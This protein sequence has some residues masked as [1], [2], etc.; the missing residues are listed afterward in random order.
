MKK[1]LLFALLLL[2][3]LSFSQK[4]FTY[5]ASF[6]P[7]LS[8]ALYTAHDT[9]PQDWVDIYKERETVKTSYSIH[10]FGEYAINA[11][12]HLTFGL[13]FQ[14][15]GFANKKKE[16]QFLVDPVTGI[17]GGG[18]VKVK[19]IWH[20]I[21]LP[22]HYKR[23]LSSKTYVTLGLIG[24]YNLSMSSVAKTKPQDGKV[25]RTKS[26]DDSEDFRNLN[27]AVGAGIGR[28]V[29][30]NDKYSIFLQGYGQYGLLGLRKDAAINRN[31]LSIGITT[32][33]RLH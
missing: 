23:Y 22:V 24:Q 8:S 27:L 20:N 26:V 4:K 6:Y 32:G 21:E 1:I 17:V 19:Y 12:S 28:D 2:P 14:N 5:G 30:V 33:I 9:V 3:F 16:L 7:N 10:V 18:T 11:N 13:G 29:I 31:I 25:E 15:T